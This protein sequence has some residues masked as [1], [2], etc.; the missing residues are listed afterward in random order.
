MKLLCLDFDGT[1]HSYSSGWQGADKI[2]DPP[3]PGAMEFLCDAMKSFRVAIFSSRSHQAGGRE[4]MQEWLYRHLNEYG[5]ECGEDSD[6]ELDAVT[7]RLM[8][9][10]EWPDHKPP[11][12]VTLDDRAITFTGKFPSIEELIAFVPW[13]KK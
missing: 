9:S 8:A 2:P 1:L 13:N 11:A 10:I 4:A 12:H 7:V 3:V 6:D 5:R